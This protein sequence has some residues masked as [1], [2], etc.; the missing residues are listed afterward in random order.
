MN[1]NVP[2]S[3]SERGGPD[4]PMNL[5]SKTAGQKERCRDDDDEGTHSQLAVA[6]ACRGIQAVEIRYRQNLRHLGRS[7]MASSVP[8]RVIGIRHCHVSDTGPRPLHRLTSNTPFD[9]T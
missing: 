9:R 1:D 2:M 5:R 8:F 7:P 4:L 6:G 3:L